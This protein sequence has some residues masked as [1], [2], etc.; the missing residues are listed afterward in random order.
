MSQGN[1][2]LRDLALTAA[3]ALNRGDLDDFLVVAHPEV[4]FT[5]MIA[6]AEGETFRGHDGVRKWWESVHNAFTEVRW[7]FLEVR[8]QGDRGVS[9][10][11]IQGTL[12]GVEVSQTMWMAVVMRDGK[13]VWWGFFRSEAEALTAAGLP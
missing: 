3:D 13:A 9:K 4:E 11:R 7:D 2:E 12:S 1:V 8:T 10:L 6:E 5:S